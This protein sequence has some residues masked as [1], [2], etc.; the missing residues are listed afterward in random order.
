MLGHKVVIATSKEL[1][2]KS[3]PESNIIGM[4]LKMLLL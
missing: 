1:V 2:L 4:L 3:S